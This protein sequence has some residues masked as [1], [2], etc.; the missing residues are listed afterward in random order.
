MKKHE[1]TPPQKKVLQYVMDHI[2]LH[3]RP[4]TAKEVA[5]AMGWASV[6]S[7]RSTLTL[8]AREKYISLSPGVSRGSKVLNN[9]LIWQKPL[10]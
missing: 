4:P 2:A 9:S 3:Q 10:V 5:K 7:A 8:L 6:N 1:L